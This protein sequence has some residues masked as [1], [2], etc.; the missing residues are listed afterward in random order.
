A[1]AS[2]ALGAVSVFESW[3]NGPIA[4]DLE[5]PGA[6]LGNA[7]DQGLVGAAFFFLLIIPSFRA[8]TAA[9]GSNRTVVVLLGGTIAAA[10][11]VVLSGSRGALLATAVGL[12]V[13]LAIATILVVRQR[14]LR[15]AR[16]FIVGVG[17]VIAGLAVLVLIT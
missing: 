16:G 13:G 15:R 6:L 1:F 5:R 10:L 4:T 2:I 17:V 12:A 9:G 3:G 7:S 14:G 11:T 8:A